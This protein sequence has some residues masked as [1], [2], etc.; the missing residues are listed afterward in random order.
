MGRAAGAHLGYRA[1]GGQSPRRAAGLDGHSGVCTHGAPRRSRRGLNGPQAVPGKRWAGWDWGGLPGRTLVPGAVLPAV[2][3]CPKRFPPSPWA[4]L[5]PAGLCTELYVPPGTEAS[6]L[7][8][9]ARGLLGVRVSGQGGRGAAAADGN[10]R[11]AQT[12]ARG[13]G[14]IQ[15]LQKH[16]R[17]S[18]RPTGRGELQATIF[19]WSLLP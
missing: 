14:A 18:A 2:W 11:W 16:H 15:Q 10:C 4:A 13:E 8:A 6:G 1:G 7:A 19:A 17:V 12:E 5:C 9:G 3:R